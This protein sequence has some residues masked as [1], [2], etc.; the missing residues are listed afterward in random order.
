MPTSAGV[1]TCDPQLYVAVGHMN[2]SGRDGTLPI[3][4]KPSYITRWG[5]RGEIGTPPNGRDLCD[6][7]SLSDFIGAVVSPSKRV[8]S[9]RT[10][11]A[12]MKNP[13]VGWGTKIHCTL[14]SRFVWWTTPRVKFRRS[15]FVPPEGWGTGPADVD[16]YRTP[17]RFQSH[18]KAGSL[19]AG[20]L[21]SVRS[22]VSQLPAIF[23]N[24][25]LKS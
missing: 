17:E 10:S 20:R 8:L 13:P 23:S 7:H 24:S 11:Y 22:R 25:T 15:R 4:N 6:D 19:C 18:K 2:M 14:R 9:G 3:N 5:D 1:E 12:R 16:I 21:K